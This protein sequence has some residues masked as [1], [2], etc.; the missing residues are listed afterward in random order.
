MSSSFA[1]QLNE[2]IRGAI[3]DFR[4]IREVF[5]TV[6]EAQKLHNT[7]NV[8]KIADDAFERLE[9][10]EHDNFC[11][12]IPL[13]NREVSTDLASNVRDLSVCHRYRAMTGDEHQVSSAY[14]RTVV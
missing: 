6:H 3:N 10:V 4:L 8:I 12:F 14:R 11:G 2:K 7:A 5:C 1:I 9:H 13:L